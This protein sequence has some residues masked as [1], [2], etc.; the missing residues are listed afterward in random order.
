LNKGTQN[1]GADPGFKWKV[2]M[3]GDFAVGKTS[4]VRR[5]VYDDFSDAYLTTIGVKVTKKTVSVAHLGEDK[6]A[7]LLLWDISGNDRFNEISAD[8]LRGAAA[9][10]IVGDVT[11]P[12]TA[13]SMQ[14]HM[15]LLHSVNPGIMC[16]FVLNKVDL[17]DD[18]AWETLRSAGI[19]PGEG[20]YRTSAKN[21]LN[22][23]ALFDGL[24]AQLIEEFA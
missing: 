23:R 14:S 16:A 19:V 24:A 11:R 12:E 7:S 6:T 5:F 4:L 13:A 21:D 18:L 20:W 2:V 15:A 3:L 10:I 17:A 9:G 22:V 8:Y 1:G